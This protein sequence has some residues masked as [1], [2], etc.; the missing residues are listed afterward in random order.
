MSKTKKNNLTVILLIIAV[1]F[2]ISWI[3]YDAYK[4]EPAD[5]NVTDTNLADENT[6]LDNIINDL[7]ENVDINSVDEND[8]EEGQNE[9]ENEEDEISEEVPNGSVTSREEKAVQLV[10]DTWGEDDSVYFYCQS[11][12]NN[13]KYIVT[14][15]K[16][17]TTV[18]AFFEVD[19]DNELVTKK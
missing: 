4:A 17:D 12:D 14:V 3:A 19:V 13:G 5:A 15:N 11:V 7:F 1:I 2:I 10:K 9:T 18:I 8:V 16:K 6:G